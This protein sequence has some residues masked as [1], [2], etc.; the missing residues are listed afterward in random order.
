VEAIDANSDRPPILTVKSTALGSDEVPLSVEDSGIDGLFTKKRKVWGW[1]CRSADP[2]LML[3][4]AGFGRHPPD[5]GSIFSANCRLFRPAMP[6]PTMFCEVTFHV[7]LPNAP[8]ARS[9]RC[10]TLR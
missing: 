3:M 4:M 8:C 10:F 5:R 2:S 1:V 9:W 6:D 7:F